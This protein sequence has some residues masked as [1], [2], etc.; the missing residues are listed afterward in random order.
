[1]K[2][3]RTFEEYRLIN[4]RGG[5]KDSNEPF[6]IKQRKN[7]KNEKEKPDQIQWSSDDEFDEVNKLLPNPKIHKPN[8]MDECGYDDD[9]DDEKEECDE[10]EDW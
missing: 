3:I 2:N 10:K 7:I 5:E 6:L 1:M 8:P 9:L 4:I